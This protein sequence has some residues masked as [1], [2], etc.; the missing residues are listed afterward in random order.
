[1]RGVGL[2]HRFTCKILSF[3]YVRDNLL[4]QMAGT[5]PFEVKAGSEV[6]VRNI[7]HFLVLRDSFTVSRASFAGAHHRLNFI[8]ARR[9]SQDFFFYKNIFWSF[10]KSYEISKVLYL[11]ITTFEESFNFIY[12]I[13]KILFRFIITS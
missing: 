2:P 7:V 3:Y 5:G 8:L 4:S 9:A 6:S 1:M 11:F 12:G 10:H 13:S